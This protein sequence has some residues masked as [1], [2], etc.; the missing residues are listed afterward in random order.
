MIAV[1][2]ETP[3]RGVALLEALVAMTILATAGVAVIAIAADGSR[4]LVH[5]RATESE[6][7]QASALFDAVA[8]WPRLDLDRH[9]G[10]RVQRN[11]RMWIER[12]TPTIYT[13]VLMDSTGHREILRTALYRPD[14]ARR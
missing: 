2:R 6:V 14:S 13:V 5:A 11:W 9:L 4:M 10:N 7:R 1:R 3:R 8:L 12:P